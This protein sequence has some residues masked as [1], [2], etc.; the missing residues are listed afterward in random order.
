MIRRPPRSTHCISSAASDVYKR[1]SIPCTMK[2]EGVINE[3]SNISEAIEIPIVE[4]QESEYK[5]V[6]KEISATSL[7]G[8]HSS[9]IEIEKLCVNKREQQ[10]KLQEELKRQIEEKEREKL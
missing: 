1:Q 6:N 5:I 10:K 2:Y 9:E 4:K 3:S 7:S 8:L